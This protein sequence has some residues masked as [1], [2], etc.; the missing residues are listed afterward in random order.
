MR[1]VWR[2]YVLKSLLTAAVVTCFFSCCLLLEQ[3]RKLSILSCNNILKIF[4][5]VKLPE[6]FTRFLKCSAVLLHI[7]QREFFVILSTLCDKR[8]REVASLLV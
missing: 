8:Q 4:K 5:N 2:D 7:T 6:C 3:T 1:K